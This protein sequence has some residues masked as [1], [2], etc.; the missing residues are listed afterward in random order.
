MAF[1]QATR[2]RLARFV[3]DAR[4]TLTLEFTR[5]LQHEYGLDPQNGT[6]TDLEKLSHLDDTRRETARLLRET[7]SHYLAG[8]EKQTVA[9]QRDVL[10]RIVREQAFT[11]LNR[12]CAL[13]MAEARG[14]LLESIARGYQS[15]GFQLYGR[16]AGSALGETGDSY[17][18]YMFSLFDEFAVDLPVLFDRFSPQGR[19]FPRPAVV[20]ELL[21]EINH[22]DI[23]PLWV[24][25]ETI[26]WIYQY[27]NSKEE[28]KQ[29]RDESSAPR[30]SR[31]LAVRNQFFT[32]RYV[33][34]FLTDNTLGRIWYE[35]TKGQTRL[36]ESCRYLVRRPHEIFLAPGEAAPEAED[37]QGELSQEE[38]LRLPV[39]I[40]HRPLKDP[41][42]IKMLDPACGSMHFGLYAFDL[43]EQIYAEAW[44]LEGRLGPDAF[45]RPEGL[46]PLRQTYNNEEE[47][48]QDVPRLIVER[49][50]HGIDIDPR[51]VQIAGLSLW[52]RA[53]KSW[54]GQRLNAVERPTIQRSNIVTAEAMPGDTDLLDEFIERHLSL[55][56][57]GKLLGQLLRRVFVAMRLAGEAGSLLKIEEEI[58]ADIAEAKTKWF[59]HPLVRQAKLFEEETPLPKQ[60]ELGL[61]VSGI[62]DAAFWGRAEQ[63][64][65]D[66][67]E[68]YAELAEDGN[69]YRR[70]LFVRSTARGF[71]F[72]DLCRQKYDVILMN[73]PF[74]ASVDRFV[75][76]LVKHCPYGNKN[77]ASAFIEVLSER[78]SVN[79]LIGLVS[80]KVIFIKS[81]YA[82]FREHIIL[83]SLEIGPFVELGWG[84]LDANVE[85]VAS[86]LSKSTKQTAQVFM[87]L[88]SA[89]NKQDLLSAG[90]YEWNQKKSLPAYFYMCITGLFRTMPNKAIAYDVPSRIQHLFRNNLSLQEQGVQVLQGHN[91]SMERYG[92]LWWEILPSHLLTGF[93]IRMYK[94]GSYCQYYQS[95]YEVALWRGD[96]SHLR[97]HS[98]TRWANEAFQGLPGIGYGKR[99]EW[100]DAHIMPSDHI[101]TVEG[102]AIFPSEESCVWGLLAYLNSPISSTLLSFYSGQ[103][104]EAGYLKDLPTPLLPL[105]MRDDYVRNAKQVYI[106]KRELDTTNECSPTF[107]QPYLVHV[108]SESIF[109]LAERYL[110]ICE[111]TSTLVFQ[112]EQITYEI[113]GLSESDI[114]NLS[115]YA[116]KPIDSVS[117][118]F[119]ASTLESCVYFCAEVAVSYAVGTAF[120]RWDIRYAISQ[121]NLLENLEPFAPLPVCPPGMLQGARNL[122]ANPDDLQTDYPM[123]ITWAG[124]MTDD[125]GHIENVEDRVRQSLRIIWLDNADAIE[126]EV[127]EI[128]GVPSLRTYFV[129]P[130]GFFS[131]HLKRYSKGRRSAPIY[132]PL[133]TASSSYTLWIYYHRLDVQT[134]YT[135]INDYVDPKLKD[136]SQQVQTLRQESNRSKLQEDD[137]A[138]LTDLETELKDFRAELL[139][140]AAF[141]RPNLND[142]VQITAAPLWRLFQHRQWQARL[143]ETWEKLEGG[144]YDWAHLAM[145]IWPERVVPQCATDRSLAI[146][147][148]IEDLFWV[149]EDGKGRLLKPQDQEIAAQKNKQRQPAHE[150]LRAHLA[151]LANGPARGLPALQVWQHLAEG[152]WDD[153]RLALY[154]W[155]ERVFDKVWDY[156]PLADPLSIKMPAKRTQA[157]RSSLLKKLL[158]AAAPDLAGPVAAAFQDEPAAFDA[159]W[160]A[161]QRGER[162][163]QPLALLLWPDRVV[164]KCTTDVDLAAKQGLRPFFWYQPPGAPWRRRKSQSSEITAEVARRQTLSGGRP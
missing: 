115:F 72:I 68:Q 5:Q 46:K 158:A 20:L 131:D 110:H 19:L 148:D 136:V 103:H 79:G 63:R 162:D 28:R 144:E 75:P 32:P 18:S 30:N 35:M 22:P 84:V 132:W 92:K 112:Q 160:Q 55:S 43:Y 147:H 102:M 164:D 54:Q 157:A 8:Q 86:I 108:L 80:D 65:Y 111:K 150:Q 120:G 78:L 69:H 31:E 14:L 73:P 99:G 90:L 38:L 97:L 100:L 57:E 85:V 71:A 77:L 156:P 34:E 104:K 139:R 140:L 95:S 40:P 59:T 118:A 70:H 76:L 29:M 2:N 143:K 153:T 125:H 124:L 21:A 88:A 24:E 83:N 130:N 66:S 17:R 27:F 151:A 62:T 49:N 1:D 12:L 3:G 155:P 93:F 53:Q 109:S 142:G 117:L 23:D 56:P 107:L 61:D 7:M 129:N 48:L 96:G 154:L 64:I 94:G 4:H 114:Q 152:Q 113:M 122:P 161:L 127:C 26:G 58:A 126:Q 141:W 91:L 51:A 89:N 135:C 25:D 47:F 123:R 45:L 82:S 116:T 44:E 6:I 137:V 119:D 37:D 16:L 36:A 98:G 128:L 163:E 42:D 74:G 138:Q 105:L 121:K 146:A 149:E 52:L 60:R 39:Y 101:F 50:I 13:R 33:V 67:L 11:V 87:N 159:V 145:S 41:R 134:L 106:L 133:S 81:T 9:G 10:E 15:K